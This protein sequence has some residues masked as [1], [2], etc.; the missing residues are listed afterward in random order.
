MEAAMSRQSDQGEKNC[1]GWKME[2]NR[3]DQQKQVKAHRICSGNDGDK[4]MKVYIVA[5]SVI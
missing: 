4:Q 5:K 1:L 2:S 3:H